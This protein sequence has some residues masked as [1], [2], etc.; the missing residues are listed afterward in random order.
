M[1]CDSKFDEPKKYAG[2]C[3]DPRN[4]QVGQVEQEHEHRLFNKVPPV[5]PELAKKLK[6]MAQVDPWGAYVAQCG[7][8]APAF[9]KNTPSNLKQ[10]RWAIYKLVDR[11]LFGN[12]MKQEIEELFKEY[13]NS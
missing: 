3:T 9:D 10:L 1:E 11:R 2:M 6:E 8:E 7:T 12:T 4:N 13:T 5:N